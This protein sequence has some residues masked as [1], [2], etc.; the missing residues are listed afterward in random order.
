MRLGVAYGMLSE[1]QKSINHLKKAE[2]I[3]K[4]LDL[5]DALL[6]AY[7]NLSTTFFKNGDYDNSLYYGK[8]KLNL[9]IKS[10]SKRDIASAQ[11]TI[12]HSY[13]VLGKYTKAIEMKESVLAFILILIMVEY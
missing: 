13:S 10:G 3:F 9:A 6:S 8:Q 7:N 5:K 4:S 11:D 2:K 1:F 12:A